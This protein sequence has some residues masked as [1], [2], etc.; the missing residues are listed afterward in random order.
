MK[1]TLVALATLSALAA[2]FT[3]G[4]AGF[5]TPVTTGHTLS[6]VAPVAPTTVTFTD[7]TAALV[8]G[9]QTDGTLVTTATVRQ[10]GAAA[11]A[12]MALAW[13]PGALVYRLV[14]NVEGN[15]AGIPLHLQ[16]VQQPGVNT[17]IIDGAREYLVSDTPGTGTADFRIA[18]LSNQTLVADTYNISVDSNYYVN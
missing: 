4:A 13:T 3:A 16:L 11:N 15:S 7:N 10:T 1:K 18:L 8:A 12:R 2:S 9:P 17:S 14:N 6:V 5:G